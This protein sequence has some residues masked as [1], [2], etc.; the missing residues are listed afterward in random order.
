MDIEAGVL[1]IF[2]IPLTEMLLLRGRTKCQCQHHCQST[3]T[4]L[5]LQ[6]TT[7]FDA[8]LLSDRS[9]ETEDIR[10]VLKLAC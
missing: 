9:W 2:L 5:K 3:N 7:N 10:G 1:T 6:R 8:L 4:S